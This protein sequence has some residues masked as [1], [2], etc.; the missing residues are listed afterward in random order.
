MKSGL[1]LKRWT[2]RKDL[3]SPKST[4]TKKVLFILPCSQLKTYDFNCQEG[5]RFCNPID[6]WPRHGGPLW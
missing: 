1:H 6:I 2:L 4:V 5:Y 3:L